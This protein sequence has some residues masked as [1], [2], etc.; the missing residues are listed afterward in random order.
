MNPGDE[1]DQLVSELNSVP[2]T[3][4]GTSGR[5][6]EWLGLVRDMNGSDLLLVAGS[7]PMVRVTGALNPASGDT[8]SGEEIEDGGAAIRLSIASA[9]IR[10]RRRRR[11][12]VPAWRPRPVPHEPAPRAGTR[13]RIHPR[14]ADDHSAV[15]DLHFSHDSLCSRVSRAGWC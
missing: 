15:R 7:A 6:E 2:R 10:R 8:L 4:R 1:L 3:Q 12:G 14:A 13:G 11:P 5:L 9:A